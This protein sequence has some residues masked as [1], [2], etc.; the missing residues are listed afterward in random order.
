VFL[1]R[2][3]STPNETVVDAVAADGSNPHALFS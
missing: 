2:A 3:N 1:E